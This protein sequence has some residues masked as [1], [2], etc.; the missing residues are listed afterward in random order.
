MYRLATKRTTKK[1]VEENAS[2]SFFTTTRALVYSDYLLLTCRDFSSSRLS[3]FSECSYTKG[4]R[5]SRS[6]AWTCNH[7]FD[8]SPVVYE[9]PSRSVP[10]SALITAPVFTSRNA[11]ITTNSAKIDITQIVLLHTTSCLHI[12]AGTLKLCRITK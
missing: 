8:S 4:C 2:V 12:G 9:R 1:R 3:G 10:R 11:A 6:W 7:R 5:S